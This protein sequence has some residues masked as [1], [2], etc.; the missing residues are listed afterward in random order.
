MHFLGR[1]TPRRPVKAEIS[2]IYGH[3]IIQINNSIQFKSKN[4]FFFQE[5]VQNPEVQNQVLSVLRRSKQAEKDMKSVSR[6]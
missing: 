2:I 6:T 3:F 4:H 5:K 1:L